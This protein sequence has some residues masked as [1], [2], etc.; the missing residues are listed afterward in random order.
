M[1]EKPQ[2]SNVVYRMIFGAIV[3]L[4]R[5]RGIEPLAFGF[6]NQHSIQLSYRRL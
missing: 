2:I 3:R 1:T 4:A 6:G 5:L